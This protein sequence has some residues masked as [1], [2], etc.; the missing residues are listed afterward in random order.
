M[1]EILTHF[2]FEKAKKYIIEELKIFKT[3]DKTS[4][5]NWKLK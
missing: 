3:G 1:R 5:L 4:I 2:Y